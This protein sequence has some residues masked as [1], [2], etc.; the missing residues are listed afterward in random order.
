[1]DNLLVETPAIHVADIQRADMPSALAW[2]VLHHIPHKNRISAI[3]AGSILMIRFALLSVQYV[4]EK[5][6]GQ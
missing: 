5:P 2:N 6:K 4:W 3:Q 1:M